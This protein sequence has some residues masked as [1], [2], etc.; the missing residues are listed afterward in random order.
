MKTAFIVDSTANLSDQYKNHP[1][2][3]TIPLEVILADGTTFRDSNRDSDIAAFYQKMQAAP[4]LPTTSQPPVG[5][6]VALVEKIIAAGYQQIFAI[7]LSSQISGTY[8]TARLLL[9]NYQDQV[10]SYVIDSKSTSLVMQFLLAQALDMLDLGMPGQAI[11]QK[12]Q[13]SADQSRVYV[14]I[15]EMDNLVKGGRLQAGTKFI[16]E[17][18]NIIPVAVFDKDGQLQ[19]Y[20]KVRTE[21]RFHK[22]VYKIF[23]QAIAA[24]PGRVRLAIAHGDAPQAAQDLADQ[25]QERYPDLAIDIAY[26][27][28]VLGVHGGRNCLG[29]SAMVSADY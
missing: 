15:R 26:L 21:K 13:W 16:G 7:H 24:Y 28:P 20:E 3:F 5:D 23:D 4:D 22:L 6:Y 2:V 29:F 19:V 27:P 1:D 12:L 18:L 14:G 25:C 17:L 9:E 11:A 10:T 8:N